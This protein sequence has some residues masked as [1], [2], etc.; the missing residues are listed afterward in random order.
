MLS[1]LEKRVIASI[2]G[3][4]PV[5]ERPYRLI[6]ERLGI[7]EAQLLTVLRDLC[8]RGV[9]RR[10][11]ATLRHQKSGFAANAMGAWRVPEAR[12]TEV[13][14]IMAASPSVSHCYRR[15]PNA[16]WPYNLY[17]MIHAGDRET[18]QAIAEDLSRR[19]G[20]SDYI[21]LFSRRELKKTSMQYF[22]DP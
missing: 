4:L 22:P 7:S 15:D 1:D 6:A 14:Q 18:C 16:R 5:T 9:I 17:T 11:G 13:G 19:T 8:D 10:F 12:V 21:L 20:I 3:D 2:Q